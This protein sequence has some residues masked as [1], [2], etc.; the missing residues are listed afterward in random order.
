MVCYTIQFHKILCYQVIFVKPLTVADKYMY[1]RHSC[2][3]NDKIPVPIINKK[4]ENDIFVQL[5]PIDEIR[6]F[7]VTIYTIWHIFKFYSHNARGFP[8]YK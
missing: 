3:I 1:I 4:I 5:Y 7:H 6:I 2:F 8:N